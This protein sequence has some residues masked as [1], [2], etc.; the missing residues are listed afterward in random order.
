MSAVHSKR[1]F[2]GA[3]SSKL[4]TATAISDFHEAYIHSLYL[5]FH[6]RNYFWY[7]FVVG[8]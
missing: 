1:G 5:S 3:V 8:I 4:P 6:K 7:A 2:W